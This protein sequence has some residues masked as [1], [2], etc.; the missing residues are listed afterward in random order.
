[1]RS[2]SDWIMLRLRYY[3]PDGNPLRRVSDRLETLAMAMAI[4]L[5]LISIW[6][7]IVVGRMAADAHRRVPAGEHQVVA[8]ILTDVPTPSVPFGETATRARATATWTT[9]AGGQRTGQ[10]DA[11]VFA[12]KGDRVRVWIDATGSP[13]TPPPGP[14][15]IWL[16][17]VCSTLFVL[18]SAAAL[19]CLLFAGFRWG[20]DRRRSARWENAWK[21]A[22]EPWRR[23]RSE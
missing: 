20:L 10:V 21:L 6:P 22:N 16:Y 14:S 17:G 23:R 9:P 18:M 7:S 12:V 1:M 5:F 4:A 13:V 3:R 15:E 8:T 19:V 11:P 2:V